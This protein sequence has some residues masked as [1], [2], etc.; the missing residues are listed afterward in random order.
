M[1]FYYFHISFILTLFNTFSILA[2]DNN[3]EL[4]IDILKSY[5]KVQLNESNI[6]I[7]YNNYNYSLYEVHSLTETD[8]KNLLIVLRRNEVIDAF[9]TI[10]IQEWE[11]DA[12][13]KRYVLQ[14][15]IEI[16]SVY[17]SY[18][19]R[20]EF[21]YNKLGSTTFAL[22]NSF[23]DESV[24]G[25]YSR[26]YII[27]KGVEVDFVESYPLGSSY[28]E[29]PA[30]L[31]SDIDFKNNVLIINSTYNIEDTVT[32]ESSSYT[33][34]KGRIVSMSE[35]LDNYA[36][37]ILRSFYFQSGIKINDSFAIRI[38]RSCDE[39]ELST[40][41][42]NN[43]YV[44]CC[45]DDCIDRIEFLR[46]RGT[47]YLSNVDIKLIGNEYGF[48]DDQPNDNILEIQCAN[49]YFNNSNTSVFPIAPFIHGGGSFNLKVDIN[50]KNI[51]SLIFSTSSVE[52]CY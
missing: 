37:E 18:I 28:D 19:K 3:Q 9:R 44:E 33:L 8:K 39:V 12:R 47:S 32:T 40:N 29:D 38:V 22:Y 2:Q 6:E 52:C 46:T 7:P 5:F 34:W 45:E 4:A 42:I 35:Y 14:N 31:T 51:L 1:R 15:E 20:G 24:Y 49:I 10:I 43:G 27:S 26:I 11:V 23:Y 13:T 17:E 30:T 16:D 48:E 36:T 41:E 50:G 21:T 25:G